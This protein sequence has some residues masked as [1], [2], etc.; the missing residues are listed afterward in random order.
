MKQV[1]IFF[2]TIIFVALLTAGCGNNNTAST[3]T[4]KDS[5]AN[6]DVTAMRK[7]IDEKN[8]QF[9]KAHITHDSA[10]MIN[11]Y[12]QDA[13]VFAPNSDVVIGRPAIAEMVSEYMKF[14]IK[15]FREETTALYGN[16]DYLINEGTYF[17]S[18]GKD[19][20][21][22][23]GKFINI[24]KKVDGDWKLFSNMWNTSMPA[25]PAK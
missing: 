12:T 21:S 16:E 20:T 11:I 14:D 3:D 5:T 13:K 6:F 10:V 19:N 23:K 4:H 22:E 2:L 1:S 8:N 9:T 18:Y 17:M 25:T 7:I 15:E 24:W